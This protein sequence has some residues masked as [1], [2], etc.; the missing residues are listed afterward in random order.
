MEV[1]SRLDALTGL[2]F[3]AAAA[4]AL[5]HLPYLH[6]DPTLPP[7]LTRLFMEGGAGVPFFF[8][9]SGFVLAYSYHDRLARPSGRELARYAVSRFARIWPVYMLSVALIALR[10]VGPLP[11]GAGA[12]AAN[13]LLVQVWPPTTEVPVSINPVA[14]SLSVEVFFYLAL[15]PMLWALARRPGVGAWALV[16]LAVAV[17]SVQFGLVLWHCK[18]LGPWALYVCN[19]CPP[20]RLVEFAVGVLHGLAF[21]RAGGADGGPPAVFTRIKWTVLELG[22]VVLVGVLAVYS[23]NVSPLLRLS[24]Y[25]VPALAMVVAAFARRRGLLSGLLTGRLPVF[26]GEVSFAFFLLHVFVFTHLAT[27]LPVDQLGSVAHAAVLVAV[28][29]LLSAAVYRWYEAPLRAWLVGLG[30]RRKESRPS[31]TGW[32]GWLRPGRRTGSTG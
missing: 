29:L 18:N 4:V 5:A 28:A 7:T 8:I 2:R 6:T 11:S 26:L 19:L 25:Y 14:W 1:K 10:P 13:L 32:L 24:G 20:V 17:W 27:R 3:L 15:P 16:S 9:L 30:R 12:V 22:A 23:D 31:P 21:V